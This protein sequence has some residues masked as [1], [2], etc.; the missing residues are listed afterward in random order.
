MQTYLK[1]KKKNSQ[2]L[3]CNKVS[4]VENNSPK[5]NKKNNF[6]FCLW[7]FY[8]KFPLTVGLVCRRLRVCP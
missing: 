1:K 3:R 8:L 7:K 6:F 5:E 4:R 2:A